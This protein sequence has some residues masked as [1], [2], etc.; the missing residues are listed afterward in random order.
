MA[1]FVMASTSAKISGPRLR[2]SSS[3]PS[4]ELSV[5]SQSKRIREVGT[6]GTEQS[7]GDDRQ[8][9]SPP[10]SG[11]AEGGFGSQAYL[12]LLDRRNFVVN[13]STRPAVSTMRFSPV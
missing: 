5:L 1:S 8:Q 2:P 13:F 11:R 10:E 12:A 7:A 6:A 4:M 9:K 3:I